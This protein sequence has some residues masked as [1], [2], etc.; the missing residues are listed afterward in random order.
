MKIQF[1]CSFVFFIQYL[2]KNLTRKFLKK[3]TKKDII[4]FEFIWMKLL[5]PPIQ[6]SNFR[7]QT[8]FVF[9]FVSVQISFSKLTRA[10]VIKLLIKEKNRVNKRNK[11]GIYIDYL[12]NEFDSNEGLEIEAKSTHSTKCKISTSSVAMH[13]HAINP[14]NYIISRRISISILISKQEKKTF[15]QKIHSFIRQYILLKKINFR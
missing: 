13:L 9:I 7:F 14:A 10:T 11:F 4:K 15:Y 1:T 12:T 8:K 6:N 3:K 5:I 2:L